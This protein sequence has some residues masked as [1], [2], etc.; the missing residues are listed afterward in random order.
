MLT[1]ITLQNFKSFGEEQTVPLRPITALIGPNNS[2]KSNLV[3]LARFVRNVV[4]AGFDVATAAEGGEE[5]LVHRP[6]VYVP[7]SDEVLALGWASGEGRYETRFISWR[8]G[9]VSH[10]EALRHAQLGDAWGVQDHKPQFAFDIGSFDMEA[11]TFSRRM[12][13]LRALMQSEDRAAGS[14]IDIVAP[15]VHA[16]EVKL[17]IT[18]LREDA[19]VVPQPRL[20]PDGSG[21]A[22]VLGLWRGSD[23]ERAEQLHQFVRRCL[24]EI[25][26]V[27]VKPSPEPAYQRLWVQQTDGQQFDAQH[28]SDGVLFFIAL[29]MH[30]IA[31]EP[32]SVLF[33]EEPEQCIHPRRLGMIMELFREIV[34]Q[35]K[36]QV[37]TITHSPVLLDELRDEPESIVLFRRG[38]RGTVVKQLTEIP[39]LV[40]ALQ[41]AEPGEMLANGFFDAPF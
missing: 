25:K 28:V 9:L 29:A 38:E 21:L 1:S 39:H 35:R 27:F 31:A 14:F 33:V 4:E 11:E 3:S 12:S 22:A 17:Q 2:G 18:A 8:H 19:E 26:H 24:P 32:G 30:A 20:S 34:A 16:R 23:P 13:N 37:I 5:F 6:A 15:I 36:C 41:N 7:G 40:D 10:T